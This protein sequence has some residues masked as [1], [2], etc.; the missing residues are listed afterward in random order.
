MAS[1]TWNW[2]ARPVILDAP[3]GLGS[4]G[5][6]APTGRLR[7]ERQGAPCLAGRAECRGGLWVP[8]VHLSRVAWGLLAVQPVGACMA[9]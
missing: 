5:R 7:V 8:W 4:S 3:L 2:S 6:P 9:V 1:M